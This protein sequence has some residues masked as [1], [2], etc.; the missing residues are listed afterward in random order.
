MKRVV[1]ALLAILG[2]GILAA[3][4]T[5]EASSVFATPKDDV[6]AGLQTTGAG[7]GCAQGDGASVDSVIAA[8]INILSVLV[9]VIAVIMVIVGGFKYVTSGGDSSSIQSAKN[10]I[11]Y[12]LIGIAIV[13]L[14]QTIV[15]YVLQKILG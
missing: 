3:V 10:T 7:A 8:V 1:F 14:S 4:F 13:A 12:A 5:P 2:I 15:K 11:I 6:C 9:G